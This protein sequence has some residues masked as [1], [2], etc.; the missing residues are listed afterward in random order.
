WSKPEGALAARHDAE[1]LRRW[2]EQHPNSLWGLQREAQ[3][4]VDA[5]KWQEAK[6]PLGK[7]IA[8][9]PEQRGADSA[10]LLLAQVHR[11]LGETG[12]ERK[13]LER[14][15][16]LSSD[17]QPAFLRLMELAAVTGDGP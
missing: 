13:V 14:L 6:G 9:D 4:L 11:Q 16:E 1:G 10:Y 3:R 17:A 15:A 8:L 12:Q 7:L 2:L 5:G